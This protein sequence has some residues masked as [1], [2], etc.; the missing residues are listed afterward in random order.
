MLN[1]Q[2]IQPNPVLEPKKLLEEI[3]R[4]RDRYKASLDMLDS[5]ET[6]LKQ[7]ISDDD[8]SEI[9]VIKNKIDDT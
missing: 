9:E 1:K 7:S 6:Q 3:K 4:Q 2:T 5:L 8:K